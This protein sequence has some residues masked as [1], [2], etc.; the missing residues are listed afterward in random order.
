MNT[1]A[2]EQIAQE[3]LL[4][5]DA[6]TSLLKFIEGYRERGSFATPSCAGKRRADANVAERR[7]L[8]NGRSSV[9]NLTA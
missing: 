6:E 2:P 7:T 3:M 9:G 5:I 4:R 8:R 1:P